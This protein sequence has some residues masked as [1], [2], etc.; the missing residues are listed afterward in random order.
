MSKVLALGS[1][2]LVLGSW[3]F[4]LCSKKKYPRGGI[5]VSQQCNK[6]HERVALATGLPG[7]W[8][9]TAYHIFIGLHKA[10][11]PVRCEARRR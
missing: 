9:C 2:L 3:I 7:W 10:K 8:Y 1:W 6:A 4:D 11:T 5:T